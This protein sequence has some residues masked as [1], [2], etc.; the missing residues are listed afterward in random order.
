ME[1]LPSADRGR[2]ALHEWSWAKRRTLLLLI[3]TVTKPNGP[4]L[5]IAMLCNIDVAFPCD[6]DKVGIA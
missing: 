5:S 4:I 3:L 1:E 6:I 2:H